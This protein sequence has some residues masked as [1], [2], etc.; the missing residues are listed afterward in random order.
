MSFRDRSFFMIKDCGLFCFR[1]RQSIMWWVTSACLLEYSWKSW[2]NIPQ[3]SNVPVWNIPEHEVKYPVDQTI[4][5]KQIFS[6]KEENKSDAILTNW[7]NGVWVVDQSQ[8]RLV[9]V[10]ILNACLVLINILILLQ[11]LLS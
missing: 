11:E 10:A 9:K 4:K 8:V 6:Y 5:S 3:L 1:W 2:R 7:T